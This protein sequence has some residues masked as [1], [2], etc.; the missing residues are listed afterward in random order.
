MDA[1]AQEVV[2]PEEAVAVTVMVAAAAAA[3]EAVAEESAELSA[4]QPVPHQ[5]EEISRSS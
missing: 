4:L 5:Q 2:S 1:A 3:R